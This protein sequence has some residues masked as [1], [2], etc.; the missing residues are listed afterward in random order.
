ML[1]P[2][3]VECWDRSRR[4]SHWLS[5]MAANHL[6]F[7]CVLDG[8]ED[9]SSVCPEL[10]KFGGKDSVLYICVEKGEVCV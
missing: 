9:E 2:V 10:M 7:K 3:I 4:E 5:D 6:G 8:F 1:L